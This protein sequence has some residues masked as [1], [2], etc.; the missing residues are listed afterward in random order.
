M[1][2]K[3]RRHRGGEGWREL[4]RGYIIL[5][6]DLLEAMNAV[7]I[8]KPSPTGCVLTLGPWVVTHF[9]DFRRLWNL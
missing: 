1:G 2:K 4:G 7:M 6:S 9:T 3:E 5:L 8:C